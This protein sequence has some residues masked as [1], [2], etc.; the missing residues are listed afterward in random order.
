MKIGLISFTAGGYNLGVRLC[1]SLE[2]AGHEAGLVRCGDEQLGV[3]T[4]EHFPGDN[5]LIFI[6]AAGIAVRAVAPHV[7][8]KTS[9]PAVLV[10]DDNAHFVVP[11]LSG[12]IGGANELAGAV[13]KLLEAIPVITTATD[14]GGIFAVDTW[15]VKQGLRIINPER[16][17]RVSALLLAG[18]TVGYRSLFPVV[19]TP[20]DGLIENTKKYDL[21]I[22]FKTKGNPLALRLVPP[23]LTLGVGCRKGVTAEELE[24]GFAMLLSKASFYREAVV[25]VCSIDLK[26]EEPGLLE[27]CRANGFP[28]KTFSSAQLN[29]VK[30]N[31]TASEFVRKTTGTDNVCERSAVLGSGG[32]LLTRK[33]AGNGMTMAFAMAPYWVRFTEE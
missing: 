15:A 28:F 10:V 9:D 31:F 22:T 19:G 5:A 21:S 13:A 24:R 27:F 33:D 16:I 3:W 18:E 4:A 26:A 32:T 30:G 1:G 2:A 6:G 7:K 11:L 8:S 29:A 20:P 14:G 23:I 25:Q 12:H 17:K